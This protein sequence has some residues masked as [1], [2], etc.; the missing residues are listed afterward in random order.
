[1]RESTRVSARFILWATFNKSKEEVTT[2][3]LS[4]NSGSPQGVVGGAVL[5]L[6]VFYSQVH[7]N[8]NN[9]NTAQTLI[10]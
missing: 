4:G 2:T 3:N 5:V 7:A 9:A 1:M 6:I 8:A 10:I